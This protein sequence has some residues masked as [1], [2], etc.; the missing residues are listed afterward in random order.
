MR[1]AFA[2]LFAAA[3]M[4]WG[5]QSLQIVTDTLPNAAVGAGYLQQLTTSGGNCQ[6][7]GTASSTID[8]GALPPG[9]SVT[10][11]ANTKQWSIA[12]TPNIA[13]TF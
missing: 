10:S 3:G 2:A 5:Q 12:G 9:L 6:G 4:L 13:G 7:D 8:S 11:P 1:Y